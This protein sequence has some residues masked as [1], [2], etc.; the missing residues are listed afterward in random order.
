LAYSTGPAIA[1]SPS[2][3]AQSQA[4]RPPKAE[5]QAVQK[6]VKAH[7]KQSSIDKLWSSVKKS[8]N[9]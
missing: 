9:I 7:K 2:P 3:T 4:Q 6:Y 1:V 8:L 5:R